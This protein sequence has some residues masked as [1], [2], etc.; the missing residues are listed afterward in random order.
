[1]SLPVCTKAYNQKKKIKSSSVKTKEELAFLLVPQW[2]VQQDQQTW[3][4]KGLGILVITFEDLL[5]MKILFN[6][7]FSEDIYIFFA[8]FGSYKIRTLTY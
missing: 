7:S 1:M 4:V 8:I 6:K 2:F 3:N 5:E